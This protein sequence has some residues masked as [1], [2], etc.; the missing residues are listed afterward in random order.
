MA[1]EQP[2]IVATS[3]GFSS[4]GLSDWDWRLGPVY[5]Y[6][7]DLAGAGSS[8]KVCILATAVGDNP[9]WLTA[10]YAANK[11]DDVLGNKTEQ[12]VPIIAVVTVAPPMT[13]R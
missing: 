6:A 5:R 7:A 1:A 12:G 3:I 2:T 8:P 4:M 13:A 11:L 10:A 9:T